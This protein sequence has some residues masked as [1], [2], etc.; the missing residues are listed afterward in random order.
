MKLISTR[1]K[2]DQGMS[3]R[4]LV[5]PDPVDAGRGRVPTAGPAR[6]R[7]HDR[8]NW[9]R[10]VGCQSCNASLCFGIPFALVCGPKSEKK[11]LKATQVD[12]VELARLK[13]G[14]K[15]SARPQDGGEEAR[16][17]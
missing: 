16:A 3:S 1:L 7:N 15:I 11:Q 17:Q 2:F 6:G 14:P 8:M 9:Q 12:R 5:I 4:S 10:V 13:L